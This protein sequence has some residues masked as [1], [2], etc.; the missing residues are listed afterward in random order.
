M[1]V[2]N[3]GLN[4]LFKELGEVDAIRFLSQIRYEKKE[5]LAIQDKLFKI[6]VLTKYLKKQEGTLNVKVLIKKFNPSRALS[7]TKKTYE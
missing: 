6:W 1:E 3:K 5:Y 4:A 2:K 7:N